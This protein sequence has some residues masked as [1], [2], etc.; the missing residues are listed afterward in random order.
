[1]VGLKA[2]LRVAAHVS[3]CR[4]ESNYGRIER[5]VS[6]GNITV[7]TKLESNYGRIESIQDTEEE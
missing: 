2:A 1:M 6:R 3:P 5:K 7:E 4:L